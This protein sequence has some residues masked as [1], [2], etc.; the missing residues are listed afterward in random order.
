MWGSTVSS[1][2]RK[3]SKAS[4]NFRRNSISLRPAFNGAATRGKISGGWRRPK[5]RGTTARDGLLWAARFWKRRTPRKRR[6]TFCSAERGPHV[7]TDKE[8]R[9]IFEE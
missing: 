8:I 7:L 1:V 3:S 4:K 9:Q 2:R 5:T 6:G